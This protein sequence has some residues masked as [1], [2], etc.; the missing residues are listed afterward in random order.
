MLVLVVV[1]FGLARQ[2]GVLLERVSPAGAL[3]TGKSVQP[4]EQV[5]VFRLTTLDGGSVEVGGKRADG[6]SSLVFFLSPT[7]S[8]CETL[9][10]VLLGLAHSEQSWLD[11][12]L[13]SDGAEED[14]AGFVERKRLGK[15]PYVLSRELGTHLRVGQLPFG[16][17]IDE[18]GAIAVAG[19]TNTREHLESLIEAKRLNVSSIQEYLEN[20][21]AAS[22]PGLGG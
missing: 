16:V 4:G 3:N 17:L 13:A 5:P 7:C 10:P 20:E 15:L 18:H 12:V 2:V 1:V 22:P 21:K 14:H 8:V 19:L 6:R 11:I 9:I